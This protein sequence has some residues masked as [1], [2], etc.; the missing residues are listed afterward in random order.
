MVALNP[1]LPL[2]LITKFQ[3]LL[4]YSRYKKWMDKSKFANQE[5]NSDDEDTTKFR[6]PLPANHPAMLKAKKRSKKIK[7]NEI[8]RPE[9][10]LKN[11][12]VKEREKERLMP[13]HLKKKNKR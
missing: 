12:K 3:V 4:L 11:R 10:I 5:H 1:P 8:L 2:Y 7:T 6:R 9:Q 13:K